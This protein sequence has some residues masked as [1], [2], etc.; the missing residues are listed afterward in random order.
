M[1]EF[2]QL[3]W[4]SWPSPWL[5]WHGAVG[6]VQGAADLVLFLFFAF[7]SSKTNF[8][9]KNKTTEPKQAA[10]PHASQTQRTREQH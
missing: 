4:P 6:V 2:K 8:T 7:F 9:T 10:T 1:I 5:L 3:S